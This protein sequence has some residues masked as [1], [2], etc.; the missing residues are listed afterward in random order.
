[1][2]FSLATLILKQ[3]RPNYLYRIDLWRVL[4]DIYAGFLG[5]V[6]GYDINSVT[7]WQK[8]V[9]KSF[10]YFVS[11][12]ALLG[13]RAVWKIWGKIIK[14]LQNYS[15]S[16]FGLLPVLAFLVFA[17][18][19]IKQVFYHYTIK[20]KKIIISI[21]FMLLLKVF[22]VGHKIGNRKGLCENGPKTKFYKS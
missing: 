14:K 5:Y 1:M 12:S 16:N 20:H 11:I 18:I 9:L 19:S 2:N 10:F 13:N 7:Q 15:I 21:Y 3:F 8:L 22:E 4:S 6:L 17:C